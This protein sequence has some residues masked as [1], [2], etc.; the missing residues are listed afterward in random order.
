MKKGR[1]GL[2]STRHLPNDLESFVH[3]EKGT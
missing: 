3:E 2:V 1:R